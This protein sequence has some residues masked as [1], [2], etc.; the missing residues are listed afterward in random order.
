MSQKEARPGE[1]AQRFR[2]HVQHVEAPDSIPRTTWSLEYQTL[3]NPSAY[4]W[5]SKFQNWKWNIGKQLACIWP[6][7]TS[8]R[9]RHSSS[10]MRCRLHITEPCTA[11]V[12]GLC[13]HFPRRREKQ[14]LLPSELLPRAPNLEARHKRTSRKGTEMRRKWMTIRS[15]GSGQYNISGSA[16]MNKPPKW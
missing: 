8:N 6:Q 3:Y 1:I 14:S 16:Q 11:V 2:V 10:R 7:S 4:C 15:S 9:E 13:A 12:R 5:V